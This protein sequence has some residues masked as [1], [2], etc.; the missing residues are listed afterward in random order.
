MKPYENKTTK[1]YVENIEFQITNYINKNFSNREK[2]EIVFYLYNYESIN[3]VN[4][5]MKV[6]DYLDD[7]IKETE[8]I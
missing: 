6:V 7:L 5:F 4:I 1:E 3:T 8:R 2:I